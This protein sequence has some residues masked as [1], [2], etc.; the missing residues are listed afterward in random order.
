MTV[1]VDVEKQLLIISIQVR[2]LKLEDELTEL[3]KK[4]IK[5]GKEKNAIHKNVKALKI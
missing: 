4:I 1:T 5:K 2:I 3:E